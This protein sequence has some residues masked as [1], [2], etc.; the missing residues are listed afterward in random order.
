MEFNIVNFPVE[1]TGPGISTVDQI[2]KISVSYSRIL[3][4]H[5][6]GGASTNSLTVAWSS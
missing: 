2:F 5:S 6:I 1:L 4:G 3:V